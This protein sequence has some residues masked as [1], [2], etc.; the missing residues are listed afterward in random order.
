MIQL[1][2]WMR[3]LV[4]LRRISRELHRMNDIAEARLSIEFPAQY[5]SGV[6]NKSHK[7]RTKLASIGYPS[8]NQWNDNWKENHPEP[9]DNAEDED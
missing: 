4:F 2:T 1:F 8:V 9:V 7:I 5:K 6:L 3:G